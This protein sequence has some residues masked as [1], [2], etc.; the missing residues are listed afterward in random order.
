M[1]TREGEILSPARLREDLKSIYKMGYFTDVKFDLSDTPQGRILTVMVAEKP[2]IKEIIT[3]GNKKIKRD[4][5][6]EVMDLKPFSVA[7]EAAIRENINK[8]MNMYREKGFYEAQIT[9]SLEPVSNTEVNLVLKI[10]EGGKLAI[11]EI[12]F[13][14]NKAFK[15]KE[16]RSVMET[17]ERGFFA[18]AWITGVGQ[19]QPGYPGAGP[20][21]S[22]GVLLQPRLHQGQGGR[23]QGRNQGQ[24]DLHHHPGPGGAP[25]SGG[26]DRPPRRLAGGQR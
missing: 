25:I 22:L 10:N 17:K 26:Q 5:I 6:L 9:Y 8:I 11:K 13:E 3:K 14:G 4:T 2:A 15:A 1:Q 20:G 19:T 12:D 7:S 16:L 21:K 18:V 23:T 24:V